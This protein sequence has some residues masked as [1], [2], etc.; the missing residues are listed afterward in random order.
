MLRKIVSCALIC[1]LICL[2]CCSCSLNQGT[3]SGIGQN[4]AK[5]QKFNT[6][7]IEYFDTVSVVV[8]YEESQ[9]AFDKTSKE[10]EIL[11][12]EYHKLYD[13]YM[14]YEGI[15]N[16]C[17]INKNAGKEPVKVDK[18]IIELLDY[19]REIYTLTNGKVN[20]AMGSVLSIWHNYR[21]VGINDPVNASL[22]PM[23]DLQ[24]AAEHTDI[25]DIIIDRENSTVF[26]TDPEMKLDVGAVAKGYATEKIAQHLI[27]KGVNHYA[28][29]FGGNIRT[30]GNKGDGTDWSAAVTNPDKTSDTP[31]L[32]NV[33]LNGKVFV[34][35]GSYERFYTVKGKDYHHIINPDTLMPE[36]NFTSISI[37]AEDSG[38]AD[39]LSTA[40]FNMTYEEGK[41][42]IEGL[43]GVEAM[44]ITSD[45]E[46]L[47]SSGFEKIIMK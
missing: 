5:L 33:A 44:W 3:Q 6:S 17:T 4:G 32:M 35:S 23:A 39:V 43:K 22:P 7:Y 36:N 30:I 26:L 1:S 12:K 38:L 31:Y 8:G 20:V 40:T 41:K 25:D 9:E 15:N 34:T 10:I 42:L 11:L 28:L 47:Y 18:K 24:K 46:I 27:S 21:N 19:C 2:I 13:I 16:I 29:N 37:Y 45:Y 14:S